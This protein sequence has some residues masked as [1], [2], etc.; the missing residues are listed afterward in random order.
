MFTD[1]SKIKNYLQI[2]QSATEIMYSELPPHRRR[3][4]KKY[5]DSVVDRVQYI[6]LSLETGL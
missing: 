2:I 4:C 1:I 6:A 3:G 5:L